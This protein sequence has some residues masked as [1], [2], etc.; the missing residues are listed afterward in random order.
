MISIEVE[1]AFDK[2][3]HPFVIKALSKLGI[4]GNFLNM[5]KGTYEPPTNNV[6]LNDERLNAFLLKE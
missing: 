4:K 3:Q 6:I 5:T 2:I 1:N